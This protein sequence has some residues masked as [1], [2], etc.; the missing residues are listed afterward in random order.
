MQS[1]ISK[2]QKKGTDV[3]GSKQNTRSNMYTSKRGLSYLNISKA[4]SQVDDTEIVPKTVKNSTKSNL[5]L[6]LTLNEAC[7]NKEDPNNTSTN[8]DNLGYLVPDDSC[9][10]EP[11]GADE[12]ASGK[13][14]VLEI[15]RVVNSESKQ[16]S[17][18]SNSLQDSNK[19][20]R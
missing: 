10:P 11:S 8:Q 12:V 3:S 15:Y 6:T 14:L 13:C 5:D 20:I 7:N 16:A 2:I 19:Y 9:R 18:I 17:I 4:K 1:K